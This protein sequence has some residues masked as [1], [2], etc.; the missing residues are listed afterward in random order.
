MNQSDFWSDVNAANKTYQQLKSVQKKLKIYHD[1]LDK[2]HL[3]LELLSIGEEVSTHDIKQIQDEVDEL[4]IDTL[5]NGE[6]DEANCPFDSN[7]HCSMNTC[8]G[9]YTDCKELPFPRSEP[10]LVIGGITFAGSEDLCPGVKGFIYVNYSYFVRQDVINYGDID[11]RQCIDADE[12]CVELSGKI[13]MAKSGDVISVDQD[14]YCG[15]IRLDAGDEI[16]INGNGHTL[17]FRKIEGSDFLIHPASDA[18]LHIN[19][20]NI[21]SET[22]ELT[23]DEK[24]LF[25]S[26]DY[27]TSAK[28]KHAIFETTSGADGV[29]FHLEDSKVSI[30]NDT[31]GGGSLRTTGENTFILQRD[32]SGSATVLDGGTLNVKLE[33]GK[34]SYVLQDDVT[35]NV[36]RDGVVSDSEQYSFDGN[37]ITV[38]KCSKSAG[39]DNSLL[40]WREGVCRQVTVNENMGRY[41]TPQESNS[42]CGVDTYLNDVY[43][44]SVCDKMNF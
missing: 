10:K 3:L 27:T 32:A 6:Y 28:F 44:S 13:S 42:T 8:G 7:Y 4:E 38:N 34:F 2:I 36:I 20:L 35:V 18:S 14:M 5:L 9:K 25:L 37:N 19:N 22:V 11:L 12:A 23:E 24:K 15:N 17:T 43:D 39:Q 16:S 29:G 40:N 1:L 41:F 26:C 30:G 21:V 31:S 33:G